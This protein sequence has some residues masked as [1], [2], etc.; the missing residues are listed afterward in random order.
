MACT[1]RRP[2]RSDT[3]MPGT[4]RTSGSSLTARGCPAHKL[5]VPSSQSS[6]RGR[7]CSRSI[8]ERMPS[9]W[10]CCTYLWGMRAAPT[11]RM[12][13]TSQPHTP[14]TRLRCV[15]TDTSRRRMTCTRCCECQPR[16][17]Q[18][19]M[20]LAVP[21]RQRTSS[22]AGS[23]NKRA[24]HSHLLCWR[25][26]RARTLPAV[27]TSSRVG[28]RSPSCTACMTTHPPRFGRSM[29]GTACIRCAP[30]AR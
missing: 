9:R 23:R 20:P 7:G 12:G 3:S 19:R 21:H 8:A 30:L 4:A 6:T 24:S 5:T 18:G 16:C 28:R 14:R 11:R 2:S 15:Q 22:P 25:K 17:C 13:S 27:P 10:R 26:Y 29:P 1:T